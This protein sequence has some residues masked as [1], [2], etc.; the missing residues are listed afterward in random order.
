MSTEYFPP[1]CASLPL[2]VYWP[3]SPSHDFWPGLDR[4]GKSTQSKKLEEYLSKAGQFF[5]SEGDEM[6]PISGG[7]KQVANVW[8][9]LE[10]NSA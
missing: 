5:L 10:R 7:I 6:P 8:E 3:K 2:H 4:S 9:I 1:F